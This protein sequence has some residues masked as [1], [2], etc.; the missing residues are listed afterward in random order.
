MY[1][2]LYKFHLYH[3]TLS[4]RFRSVHLLLFP[5]SSFSKDFINIT[6]LLRCFSSHATL[7]ENRSTKYTIFNSSVDRVLDIK[8][9]GKIQP[10]CHTNCSSGCLR[11]GYSGLCNI[12]E[13]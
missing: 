4:I 3:C 5:F 13:Y 12:L 6:I 2:V 7:F 1:C 11:S 9:N 8:G 10:S